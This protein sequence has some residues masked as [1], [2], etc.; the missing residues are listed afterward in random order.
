[1]AGLAPRHC[2]PWFAAALPRLA[3][4]TRVG[5]PDGMTS[6]ATRYRNPFVSWVSCGQLVSS[7]FRFSR[8]RLP[9]GPHHSSAGVGSFTARASNLHH[10]VGCC[11]S[12]NMTPLLASTYALRPLRHARPSVA[13]VGGRRWADEVWSVWEAC[14]MRMRLAACCCV[15]LRAFPAGALCMGREESACLHA[16]LSQM[17]HYLSNV[18]GAQPGGGWPRHI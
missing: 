17:P 18:V 12:S 11:S 10:R 7:P 6:P 2:K 14:V 9:A 1:M 16:R 13:L 8:S 4:A 15:L 3:L 5:K